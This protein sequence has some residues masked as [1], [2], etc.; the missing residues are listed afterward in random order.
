MQT[1]AADPTRSSADS[2]SDNAEQ[3]ESQRHM[4]RDAG[5]RSGERRIGDGLVAL[6]GLTWLA[7]SWTSTGAPLGMNHDGQNAGVFGEAARAMVAD[8]IGSHLG[9]RL[10][11]GHGVYANHPPLVNWLLAAGHALVGDNPA[12]LRLPMLI[13]ALVLIGATYRL[14]LTLDI[15]PL[16]AAAGT[17]AGLGAPMFFVFGTM[18]DTPMLG[19]PIAVLLIEHVVRSERGGAVPRWRLIALAALSALA[20]WEAVLVAGVMAVTGLARAEGS[21]ADRLRDAR[22]RADPI[23]AGLAAGLAITIVW[24]GWGYGGFGKIS[25]SFA[26]RIGASSTPFG[27]AD[28]LQTQTGYVRDVYGVVLLAGLAAGPWAMRRPTVRRYLP[29]IALTCLSYQVIFWQAAT[30]HNYWSYWWQ[31]PIAIAIGGAADAWRATSRQPA[32]AGAIAVA[33]A[34]LIGPVFTLAR[35]SEADRSYRDGITVARLIASVPRPAGQDRVVTLGLGE[36]TE[37]VSWA[38]HDP[39]EPVTLATLPDLAAD[40]PEWKVIVS[41]SAPRTDDGPPVCASL[42]ASTPRAAGVA[43]VDAAELHRLVE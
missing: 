12:G 14:L 1:L 13:A 37:W 42:P 17:I 8:P 18:P 6:F 15:S 36:P 35:E 41:C 10:A 32:R 4:V 43:I 26:S 16:A 31:L 9:S 30:I 34:V 20:G 24:I 38:S 11:D 21:F 22:R 19:L 29:T 23:I 5:R 7:A 3:V 39:V 2:A 28:A 27:V 40:H 25:E 33:A